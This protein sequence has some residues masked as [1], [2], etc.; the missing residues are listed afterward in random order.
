MSRVR[1]YSHA[2]W[3]IELL[4]SREVGAGEA[5]PGLPPCARMETF[6]GGIL[7]AV[8]PVGKVGETD[9]AGSVG[10]GALV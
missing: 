6:G 8:G 3:L 5:R 9:H 2:A 10:S 4:A 1:C 7:P